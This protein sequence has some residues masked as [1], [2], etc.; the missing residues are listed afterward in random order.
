[1][2]WLMGERP[3]VASVLN[4]GKLVGM[5]GD[6]LKVEFDAPLYAEMVLE[7][8]RRA[9]ID[10][11]LAKH[12]GHPMKLEVSTCNTRANGKDSVRSK[13]RA[14]KEALEST[15]VRQAA[16]IFDARVHE[17]KTKG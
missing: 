15:L 11:L 12:F 4:H 3:Q 16:E 1:M 9:Q 7:Q 6:A 13:Q 2:R 10:E 17:V 5:E 14:T 8:D